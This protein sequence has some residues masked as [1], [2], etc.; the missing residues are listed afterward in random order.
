MIRAGT[1]R[2]RQQRRR[3]PNVPLFAERPVR[4]RIGPTVGTVP[5]GLITPWDLARARQSHTYRLLTASLGAFLPPSRAD[6]R[7]GGRGF[8]PDVM[9]PFSGRP[10]TSAWPIS[11]YLGSGITISPE[12]LARRA[13]AQAIEEARRDAVFGPILA[14][15]YAGRPADLTERYALY[16]SG[17]W[18]TPAGPDEAAKWIYIT[19]DGG[20]ISTAPPEATTVGGQAVMMATAVPAGSVPK[21]SLDYPSPLPE[22]V[23]QRTWLEQWLVGREIAAQRGD[24]SIATLPPRQMY[25]VLTPVEIRPELLTPPGGVPLPVPPAAEAKP[26]GINPLLLLGLGLRLLGVL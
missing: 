13:R 5:P 21:W 20:Q 22:G 26:A 15:L 25:P 19:P 9:P 2:Y 3:G 7:P 11:T 8:A 17:R 18:P 24:F 23:E 14:E 10:T 6:F 4:G 12:E 16:F 1:G